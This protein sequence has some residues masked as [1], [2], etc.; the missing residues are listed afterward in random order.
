MEQGGHMVGGYESTEESPLA[1]VGSKQESLPKG[2][3][4]SDES[5]RRGGSWPNGKGHRKPSRKKRV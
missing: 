2:K 4:I 5:L 3:K 1:E